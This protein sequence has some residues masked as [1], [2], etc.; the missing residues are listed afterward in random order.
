MA[1]RS[2]IGGKLT[3][4]LYVYIAPT[5]PLGFGVFASR[6][7]TAGDVI[8]SDED[9]SYFDLVMT[10]AE[11]KARGYDV[12]DDV[13]QVGHDAFIPATGTVDDFMNHSCAPNC[14]VRLTPRGYQVVAL[15]DIARDE[16][17]TYDYSTYMTAR[18]GELTCLCGAPECR[19]KISGFETLSAR[20][21]KRYVTLGVAGDFAQEAAG[22]RPAAKTAAE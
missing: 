10:Y 14:G 12:H 19:G 1:L 5:P 6:P 7:W 3:K 16:Q 8:I 13:V 2:D 18:Y 21:R 15:R 20:L 22:M 9:G 11:L 4:A 17:L